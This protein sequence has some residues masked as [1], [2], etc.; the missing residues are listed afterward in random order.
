LRCAPLIRA[1]CNPNA[2]SRVADF[3]AWWINPESG[4]PIPE[5]AGVLRYFT[6]VVEKIVWADRPEELMQDQ[7]LAQNLPP[8]TDPPRPMSVT[9]IPAR[10]FDN[11][12]LLKVNPEYLAWL[13][14][15]RPSSASGCW[16]GIGR[17]GRPPGSTSSGIGVRL[18]TRS[19]PT[20]MSS[21]I[22]ISR[23]P[24]RRRSTTPI[25]RS[26]PNS[27]ATRT[28]GY[29]L[30]D[31]VR[32]R[33]NPGDVEKLLLGTAAHDGKEVRIGF[34]QDPGQAGESQA[35]HL[36]RALSGFTATPAPESGDKL[37]RF[38]PLSS[39]CRAGNVKIRRGSWNEELFRVLEGFPD[40]AHD[41]EVDAC[42]EALEMLNPPMKDFG[43]YELYRQ[44]SRGVARRKRVNS[45]PEC[46]T[47]QPTRWHEN[48]LNKRMAV[49]SG[50][51]STRCGWRRT[52]FR[53]TEP[54]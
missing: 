8:G 39:Q 5:R 50:C 24:R 9:F 23:P 10:V 13:C 28:G 53:P 19:R 25:G 26:A 6:R 16:L 52:R 44:Q 35:L 22:G 46:R 27:G 11:P 54:P 41:D 38:G 49:K 42:S 1:T 37:T 47:R 14:H 20:S 32:A 33:A 2:D 43:I 48:R 17:S 45:A 4:L 34:G 51:F 3:L 21:G 7:L 36:V 30:L 12:V 29:W 18:L 31:L 40:L 15:C